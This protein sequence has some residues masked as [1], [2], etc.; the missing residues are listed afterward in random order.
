LSRIGG[1]V[2]KNIAAY[3]RFLAENRFPVEQKAVVA[4]SSQLRT[5][6]AHGIAAKQPN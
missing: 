5:I 2:D 6:A 1:T 3:Q 4:P